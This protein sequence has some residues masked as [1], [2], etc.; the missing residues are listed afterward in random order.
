MNTAATLGSSAQVA[1]SSVQA[2]GSV[3]TAIGTALHASWVPIVG[4]IVAGVT[5]A[6]ILILNRQG[7]K[8]KIAASQIADQAE[9]Q[10]QTNVGGYL[11]GPRTAASQAQA[12]ANF[13]MAWSALTGPDNWGNAQ[14]GEPGR[15]AIADRSRGGKWDW[16]S[17]Y[18]DPIANDPDLKTSTAAGLVESVSQALGISS[19]GDQPVQ[20]WLAGALIAAAVLM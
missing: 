4:P 9:V 3:V 10:L 1:T 18:R 16:F 11:S 12:L 14:L 5:I 2:G 15:R 8:Q 13:D 17:Y 7:P 6:L 20:L 19:G